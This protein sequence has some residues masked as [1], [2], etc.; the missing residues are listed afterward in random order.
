MI[1]NCR[2]G[3]ELGKYSKNNHAFSKT[4]FMK[5]YKNFNEIMSGA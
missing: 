5:N 4:V 3:I 2:E 1:A